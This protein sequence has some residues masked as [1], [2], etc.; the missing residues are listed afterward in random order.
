MSLYRTFTVLTVMTMLFSGNESLPPLVAPLAIRPGDFGSLSMSDN[1]GGLKRK[2]LS[3]IGSPL[4]VHGESPKSCKSEISSPMSVSSPGSF[5]SSPDFSKKASGAVALSTSSK[6]R[7][8]RK[9]AFDE[10][11]SSPVSGTIIR[12]LAEGE[13]IPVIKTG[14]KF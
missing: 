3:S 12:E 7:I 2:M 11:K 10:D 8:S 13:E 5:S 4:S 9:L 14:G 6:R 1:G